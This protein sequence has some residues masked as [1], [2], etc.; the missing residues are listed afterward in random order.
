M[1]D[2]I[3]QIIRD[4]EKLE[5]HYEAMRQRVGL[6]ILRDSIMPV[7]AAFLLEHI[8][9]LNVDFDFTSVNSTHLRRHMM[10]HAL[11]ISLA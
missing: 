6:H 7:H 9:Q 10:Q 5:T 8:K 3:M 1:A 2:A 11:T 4:I